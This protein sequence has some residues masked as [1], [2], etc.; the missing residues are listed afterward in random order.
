MIAQPRPLPAFIP[1]LLSAN[2]IHRTDY[3]CRIGSVDFIFF[4][5]EMHAG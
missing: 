3:A 2:K 5:P 4:D 1:L